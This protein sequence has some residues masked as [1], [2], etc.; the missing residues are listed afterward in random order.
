MYREQENELFADWFSSF[1]TQKSRTKKNSTDFYRKFRSTY[2]PFFKE[3][4]KKEK[5]A[6]KKNLKNF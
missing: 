6:I 1:V 3:L 5:E 4:K 2:K